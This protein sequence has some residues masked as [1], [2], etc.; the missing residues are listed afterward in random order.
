MNWKHVSPLLLTLVIC[1][2][3]AVPWRTYQIDDNPSYTC[4]T[5]G[6]GGYEIYV[7]E[8]LNNERVVIFQWQ[9]GL[10]KYATKRQVSACGELTEFE[11]KMNLENG[12]SPKCTSARKWNS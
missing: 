7:W 2:C 4:K 5:G 6:E 1:S 11:K 10:F 9:S 12:K 8:C 3:S